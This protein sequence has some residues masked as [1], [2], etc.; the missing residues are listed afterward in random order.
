MQTVQPTTASTPEDPPELDEATLLSSLA[1]LQELQ[2]AVRSL[3]DT[4]PTLTVAVTTTQTSP[5]EL[6]RN[7]SRA[8]QNA[9]N[10]IKHFTTLMEEKETKEVFERARESR[11]REGEG[12]GTG[13]WQVAEHG[14]WLQSVEQE[15]REEIREVKGGLEARDVAIDGARAE[16][17][18][19]MVDRFRERHPEVQVALDEEKRMINV[20][21]LNEQLQ[22]RMLIFIGQCPPSGQHGF[23]DR[24]QARCSRKV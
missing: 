11:R 1:R 19:V 13:N 17:V 5:E 15:M 4:L 23:P 2:L 21:S 14:N 3:R 16:D 9:G 20:L 22:N 10:E 8:A 18:R 7:F 24:G 12:E 6:Y